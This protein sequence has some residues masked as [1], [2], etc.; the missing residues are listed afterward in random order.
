MYQIEAVPISIQDR[1]DQTQLY[2][3]LKISKPYITLNTDTFITLQSQE[4][5][6]HKNRI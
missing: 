5:G 4:L 2:S 1:N 6:T 3:Q